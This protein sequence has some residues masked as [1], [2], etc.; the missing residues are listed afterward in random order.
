MARKK[1][2]AKTDVTAAV[3]SV[4]EKRKWQIAL[5]RYVLEKKWSAAYAPFFGIG[6]ESFRDWI[7]MQFDP[8]I[9]WA[10]FAAK[11]QFDHV[12]PPAYFDFNQET[13]MAL[14]WNFTNI[15]IA[16]MEREGLPELDTLGA[17]KYFESLYHQTGYMPCRSMLDK[18]TR[19]EIAQVQ[20]SGNRIAFINQDI[21]QLNELASFSAYEFQQLHE[22]VSMNNILAERAFNAKIQGNSH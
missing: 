5:R 19:I 2:T 17:R 21:A 1:W 22:G 6:I 12:V 9:G 20:H 7:E 16:A 18:L 15:R 3:I 10:H 8:E 14:C 13:D 4:R 11:W